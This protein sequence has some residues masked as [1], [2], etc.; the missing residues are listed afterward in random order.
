MHRKKIKY[1][2]STNLNIGNRI[3]ASIRVQIFGK[4]IIFSFSILFFITSHCQLVCV[5]NYKNP[6]NSI[7]NNDNTTFFEHLSVLFS[8]LLFFGLFSSRFHTVPQKILS[9]CTHISTKC[10]FGALNTSIIKNVELCPNRTH[11]N[12]TIIC[13]K[14]VYSDVC[15]KKSNQNSARRSF[16]FLRCNN[17]L[18]YSNNLYFFH[19]TKNVINIDI[20]MMLEKSEKKNYLITVCSMKI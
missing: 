8:Q 20:P 18:N 6:R 11:A 5:M 16:T 19:L 3:L 2:A 10:F 12:K 14:F 9:L 4:Y 1:A 7:K 15:V 13:I 17:L